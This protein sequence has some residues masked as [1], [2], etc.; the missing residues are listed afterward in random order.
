MTQHTAISVDDF[1]GS[2]AVADPEGRREQSSFPIN[3]M[4]NWYFCYLPWVD[5]ILALR[6]F[7]K[8]SIRL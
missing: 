3:R 7:S 6:L 5:R 4:K 2:K 1:D 8:P